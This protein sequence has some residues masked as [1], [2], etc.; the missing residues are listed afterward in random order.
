LSQHATDQSFDTMQ[1]LI[2]NSADEEATSALG[3][4]LAAAI[5]AGTTIALDGTLGAGKTRLVQAIAAALGVAPGAAVSPTFVLVQ[6]YHGARRIVHVDAYRMRDEDEFLALGA[7]E[8]FNS[9]AIVLIEWADR[10]A[11][12]LPDDRLQIAIEETGADSRRFIITA[13]GP[14][15]ASILDDLKRRLPGATPAARPPSER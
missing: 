1:P 8:Y 4:A 7:E 14:R 13:L 10:V 6:E 9:D 11:N 15:G 3:G 12:C 5:P 2:F